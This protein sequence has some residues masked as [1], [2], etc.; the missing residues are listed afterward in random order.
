MSAR[1]S[2]RPSPGT[3]MIGSCLVLALRL[4]VPSSFAATVVVTPGSPD[5]WAFNTA[6]NTG[7]PP[8]VDGTSVGSFAT[9]PATPPLGAGS[10]SLVTGDGVVGGDESTQLRNE[11][12]DGLALSDLTSLQYCTYGTLWNGQQLPYLSLQIDTTGSGSAPDDQI[13]FEPAYQQPTTGNPCLPDQGAAMLGVWQCWDALAGAWWANSGG[14]SPTTG[15]TPGLDAPTPSCPYFPAAPPASGV[16]SLE[17]YIAQYPA[18]RILNSTSGLGGVRL[19]VGFASPA[20]QF[21]GNVDQFVIGDPGGT[22]TYDFE[23]SEPTTTTTTS[24]PVTTT[25]TETTT[26]TLEPTTTT[27]ETTTTTTETTT[28][29]TETTT[30]TTETTTTTTEPTTTTT[31]A[32]TTTTTSSTTST[33]IVAGLNVTRAAVK[34]ESRPGSANGS[35]KLRGDFETPPAFAF[36]PPLTLR[37]QDAGTLDQSHTYTSCAG[38]AGRVKCSD[39]A[40]GVFKADF[41]PLQTTPS[42]FRFKASFLRLSL[43][44][45][46]TPPVTVTLT[47]DG[48]VVRTNTIVDCRQRSYGLNCREF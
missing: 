16:C 6:D 11:D 33:T 29:T 39:T 8:A 44:G 46:F 7:A 18:A 35:I 42:V 10:A 19:N 13:F 36:P 2:R 20:D 1:L 38:T 31:I 37:V 41:R 26:T 30:T 23:L 4:A 34:R 17:D 14:G 22:T 45:P 15:C 25:T 47:H 27:T 9:G 5:G 12:F 3:V 43:V 28:T 24:V 48:A 40:G 21:D 32:T